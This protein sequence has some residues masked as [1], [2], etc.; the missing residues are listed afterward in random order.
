ME[1]DKM[2]RYQRG[3]EAAREAAITWQQK[4]ADHDYSWGELLEFQERF[5]ALAQRFGLIKEFRENGIP[6]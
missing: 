2:S 5:R 1:G 6:V 3:K 4:F